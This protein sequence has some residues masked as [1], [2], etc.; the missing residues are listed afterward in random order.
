MADSAPIEKL[1]AKQ[2]NAIAAL[3]TQP[4]VRSAAESAGVP[5]RTLYSWL[6]QPVFTEEYRAARREA[7]NQAIAR[8]QSASSAAV[9][10]L[11]RIMANETTKPVV[12]LSAAR[13]VLE[14][15]IKAV[16]LDDLQARLEALERM[17]AERV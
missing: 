15:A 14:L 11:L 5:E 16:E 7:T 10:V 12:R 6:K 9:N 2:H 8:L 13:T 3:L 4:N 17:Y 1:S